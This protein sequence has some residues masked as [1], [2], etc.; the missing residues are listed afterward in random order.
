MV[1]RGKNPVS[2]KREPQA[3]AALPAIVERRPADVSAGQLEAKAAFASFESGGSDTR[4]E[5]T[6]RSD[7]LDFQRTDVLTLQSDLFEGF[8]APFILGQK[9]PPAIARRHGDV[10]AAAHFGH[11]HSVKATRLVGGIDLHLD[12]RP[13]RLRGQLIEAGAGGQ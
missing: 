2:E 7:R 6:P 4:P 10:D 9:H 12:R 5:E 13:A 1:R 8:F 3:T 11:S